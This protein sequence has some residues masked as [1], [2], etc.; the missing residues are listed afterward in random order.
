MKR[1]SFFFFCIYFLSSC[2][3]FYT[4]AEPV[5]ISPVSKSLP[6]QV[7][8]KCVRPLTEFAFPVGD[9]GLPAPEQEKVL[10]PS[11]WSLVSTV[12]ESTGTINSNSLDL[13]IIRQ[14]GN[15][16]EMWILEKNEGSILRFRTNPQEWEQSIYNPALLGSSFLFLDNNNMVWAARI[17]QSTGIGRSLLSRYNE[18]SKSFEP[19]LDKDLLLQDQDTS[20]IVAL[21]VDRKGIFWMILVDKS[22]ITAAETFHLFSFDPLTLKAQDHIS[23]KNYAGTLAIGPDNTIYLVDVENVQLIVYSQTTR[24][25]KTIEIPISLE[26][27]SSVNLY[28][29]NLYLDS[30]GH[31]WINDRGWFD[32]STD[33]NFPQWFSVV[34]SPIFINY[35]VPAGMWVWTRPIFTHD[36]PNALI[37]HRS[38]RG[39]GWLDLKNGKWCLITTYPSNILEDQQHNLW[40]LINGSLYKHSPQY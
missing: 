9:S 35:L 11:D 38:S 37:W 17:Y 5:T 25:I 2:R 22:D 20:T 21:K 29:M 10:P 18:N 26:S 30:A 24:K 34:R 14:S 16:E 8:N 12:S 19:V 1:I 33:V 39:T 40:M 4:P 13:E 7:S 27:S 15:G 28:L 32:F 3:P 31:L 36:G 6:T 23:S